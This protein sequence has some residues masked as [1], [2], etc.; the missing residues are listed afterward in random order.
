[1]W[2]ERYAKGEVLV[3]R[4]ADDSVLGFQYFD[5]AK[6]FQRALI[7]R[8]K[9]FGLSLHPQKTRLIRFG[10]FAAERD[11]GKRPQTFDFLGFTHYC[12]RK[13]DGRFTVGRRTS[14]SDCM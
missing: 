4:Y 1:M 12:A 14:R 10:Q 7:M 2:R 5:D 11:D 9:Q 6:R 8:L 3:V 13:R